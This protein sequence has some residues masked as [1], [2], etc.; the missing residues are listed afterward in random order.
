MESNTKRQRR[1]E[2]VLIFEYTE[3]EHED[4]PNNVT[5]VKFHSSV[6]EVGEGAF[7]SCRKLEDVVFNEGLT[8]I[9]AMA[10]ELCRSLES[11]DLP[12]TVTEI[13]TWAFSGCTNLWEVVFNEGLQRIR[14]SAFHGCIS[15]ESINFPSTVRE[16]GGGALF[17]CSNLREVILNEGLQEIGNQAFACCS[18][19]EYINLPST[20]NKVGQEA[21]VN[22]AHLREVV[23]NE[24]LTR[25]GKNA[26]SYCQSLESINIPSTVSK[27][28]DEAFGNCSRLREVVLNGDGPH[29]I[30][31]EAFG[32][33]RA[34]VR[35]KFS[36]ISTRLRAIIEAGYTEIENK[37]DRVGAV[38]R[39]GRVI[40]IP[41]ASLRPPQNLP[42]AVRS[43]D[44]IVS[45]IWYY[46]MKEATTIFELALWKAK[47]DH[48]ED[49]P[50]DRDACRIDVPGPVKD[51]ILKYLQ[52]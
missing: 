16:L 40:Y 50:V 47:I 13:D 14:R 49:N 34:L 20:M 52:R 32:G 8:K 24:G 4:A 51:A 10:F 21:F 7:S 43:L 42:G 2:P 28:D 46:E 31:R 25:I 1:Q 5:H 29:E 36:T 37:I 26:F 18:S 39:I 38:E 11:I 45:L 41:M 35:V 6:I 30:G 27:I 19:L 33:R 3:N 22:S 17:N 44:K 12:S 48:A 9:G 15:L 23:F